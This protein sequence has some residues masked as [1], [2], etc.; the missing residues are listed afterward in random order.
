MPSHAPTITKAK[1]RRIIRLRQNIPM[2][3]I[4]ALDLGR[5]RIGLA[6]SDPSGTLARPLKTISVTKVNAV[7]LIV[8]EIRRLSQEEDGLHHLVVGVPRRLDGRATDET[9]EVE[10]V[11]GELRRVLELP[12]ETEDERLTSHEAESRLALREKDWR[13]R[14]SMLD[15]E[16]ASIILQDHLDRRQPP[17]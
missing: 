10:R 7:Q 1:E 17:G 16:A 8:D 11:I 4:L 12:I 2:M 14:K 3:R 15:A 6:I 9:A 5:R 13:K